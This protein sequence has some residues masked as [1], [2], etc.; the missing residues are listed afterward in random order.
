LGLSRVR[1]LIYIDNGRGTAC[2][3]E[4]ADDGHALTCCV[5]SS[6]GLSISVE[7]SDAPGGSSQVKEYLG[8]IIDTVQMYVF[9]PEHKLARVRELLSLFLLSPRHTR[10]AGSQ[11]G[12]KNGFSGT[13]FGH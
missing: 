5:L 13:S 3:K 8:F 7:K 1:L 10:E 9:V 6:A 4:K 11:H 2:S 12:S